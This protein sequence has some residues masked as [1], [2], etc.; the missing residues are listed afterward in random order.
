MRAAPPARAPRPRVEFTAGRCALGGRVEGST[1]GLKAS[2]QRALER[3]LRRRV[4]ADLPVGPD[5]ARELSELSHALKRRVGVLIDR[6]GA[7]RHALVGDARS[8]TL[9]EL[10]RFRRGQERLK[11]LR[12]VATSLRGDEPTR[13]DLNALLRWRLDLLLVI[14]VGPDGAPEALREAH[15]IPLDEEGRAFELGPRVAPG[16]ARR[17]LLAFL[18]ELEARFLAATPRARHTGAEELQPALLAVASSE[19]RAAIEHDLAEL[20]ELA[21]AAGLDVRG[22]LTQRRERMDPKTLFGRG[23]VNDLA[24]LALT[25]DAELVVTG[26]ELAPRQQMALEDLLGL[27]VIDRTQLILDLFAR[28]ARTHAGKLQV[29]VARLRYMLPRL[30]GRGAAMSR[31]GGGKGAGF[32]RTKGAGERKLEIDRRRIRERID[33]LERE[34]D[35]LRRQRGLRRRRRRKNLLPHVA[36]VGY[37]NVG[38]STLLNALTNAEV[39]AENKL[40][41]TLDPTTRR[42]RFPEEREIVLTDTVGFIRDLPK[43]LVNAFRATLEE[44]ED[45]DLLLH[46]IDA[47]DPLADQKRRAVEALLEDLKLDHIPRL[48][49]V[50]KVDAASGPMVSALRH[51]N[52]GVA[53]SALRREGLERLLIELENQVFKRR[54]DREI[55][56]TRAH[57]ALSTN[58]APNPNPNPNPDLDIDLGRPFTA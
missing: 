44:L 2:E 38:K 46:V 52:R 4:E 12:W 25:T 21:R 54:H 1:H 28:R 51:V 34:L 9:P 37:T 7:V 41:A 29:E 8:L 20:R 58:A 42:L 35:G 43:D 27:T 14:A 39:I 53:V 15:L 17:D 56:E 33:G 26:A 13:E 40:F 55:E 36:L 10:G 11:G 31:V 48:V 5:L 16:M 45:S 30:L 49:V 50:N 32:A 19:S 3:L 47:S 23:R 22:E 6:G 57:L 18:H 24:A